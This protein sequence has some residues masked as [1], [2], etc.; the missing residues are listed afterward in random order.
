MNDPKVSDTFRAMPPLPPST[1]KRVRLSVMLIRFLMFHSRIGGLMAF[2][3]VWWAAWTI[4]F[5]DFWADW[6]VTH[7]I[8][9]QTWGYPMVISYTLLIGG[10]LGYLSKVK[11]WNALRSLCLLSQFACWCVLTLVFLDVE[12]VFSPGVAC[13]SAFALATLLAYVNFKMDVFHRADLLKE[14]GDAR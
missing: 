14:T 8:T 7:Q 3:S 1:P 11:N 6:P 10:M 12:P 4:T 9:V 2:V 13:Y 5:N